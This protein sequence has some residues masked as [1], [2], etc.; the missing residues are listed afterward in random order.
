MAMT[1]INAPELKCLSVEI[2][3]NLMA[4]ITIHSCAS[5]LVMVVSVIIE[6]QRAGLVEVVVLLAKGVVMDE[7]VEAAVVTRTPGKEDENSCSENVF[8]G[9]CTPPF[10]NLELRQDLKNVNV[11]T[12]NITLDN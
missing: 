3:Q 9:D 10:R 1:T 11:V 7:A 8:L 12:P 2:V 4:I 5:N 6:I